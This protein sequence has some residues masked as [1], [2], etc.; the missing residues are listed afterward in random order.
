MEDGVPAS[1]SG[2]SLAAVRSVLQEFHVVDLAESDADSEAVATTVT[3]TVIAGSKKKVQNN[4]QKVQQ[5]PCEGPGCATM[6]RNKS[7]WTKDH[8]KYY[9]RDCYDTYNTVPH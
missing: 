7:E 3:A 9:C 8:G 5:W 1:S 4:I 6:M 2:S